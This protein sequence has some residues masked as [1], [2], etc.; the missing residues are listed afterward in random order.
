[1]GYK[2]VKYLETQKL[3][4]AAN[5][6]NKC[7]EKYNKIIQEISTATVALTDSWHGEGCTEFEKD[8]STIYQQLTDISDIM[9]DLYESLVDS[10][11]TYVQTDEDI[12]KSL[13][14]E[15]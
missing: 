3:L 4:D 8:Y 10:D 6:I 9:Y 7:I 13:T 12:A 15:G 14:M 1:M 11:A 2:G 5:Q